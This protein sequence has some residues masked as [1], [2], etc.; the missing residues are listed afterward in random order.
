MILNPT[1]GI[2]VGICREDNPRDVDEAYGPGTYARLFPKCEGCDDIFVKT[3]GE[4]CPDCQK[5]NDL[6]TQ[7]EDPAKSHGRPQ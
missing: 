2:M 6:Q 5:E 3:A 4:F 7:D 1:H